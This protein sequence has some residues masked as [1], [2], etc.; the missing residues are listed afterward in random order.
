MYVECMTHE[1]L[2]VHNESVVQLLED[3]RSYVSGTHDT[4]LT[5]A[6]IA[7]CDGVLEFMRD[8]GLPEQDEELVA[9]MTMRSAL[10]GDLTDGVVKIKKSQFTKEQLRVLT[11]TLLGL[12]HRDNLPFIERRRNCLS[13]VREWGYS[14]AALDQRISSGSLATAALRHL[15][16]LSEDRPKGTDG[17]QSLM[18]RLVVKAREE[19]R[20]ERLK[21]SNPPA[22]A[23][24]K[25]ELL[26]TSKRMIYISVRYRVQSNSEVLGPVRLHLDYSTNSGDDATE[27]SGLQASLRVGARNLAEGYIDVNMVGDPSGLRVRHLEW[28]S[29]LDDGSSVV[30]KLRAEQAL[31][32]QGFIV[33]NLGRDLAVDGILYVHLVTES[34]SFKVNTYVRPSGEPDV[35][36]GW[37]LRTTAS[38]DEVVRLMIRAENLSVATMVDMVFGVNLPGYVR[39][40]PS[41]TVIYNMTHPQGIDA[42]SD[43]IAKGGINIGSYMSKSVA[44]VAFSVV[45]DR[46]AQF[47]KIGKYSL[48]F[49]GIARPFGRNETYNTAVLDVYIGDEPDNQRK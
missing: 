33:A 34:I 17:T 13:L 41:S 23:E 35:S 8:F 47:A 25:V 42:G 43:N 40:I 14:K 10:I 11:C 15:V 6:A 29:H 1:G 31:R 44:Y 12:T 49:V 39:Y 36:E 26:K 32:R 7:N 48:T 21:V 27:I 18:G 28:H 19:L 9:W 24:V 30:E 4:S 3:L 38:P 37:K 2:Q 46:N 16:S 5:P 45:V 20:Q 22:E